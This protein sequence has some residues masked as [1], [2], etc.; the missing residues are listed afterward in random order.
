[1]DEI[2][3]QIALLEQELIA[4][5]RDFH[6]HPEL[7]FQ[8]FETA[9]KIENYLQEIGL[10]T[11]RVASTG[12]VATLFGDNAGKTIGLRADMDALPIDE[13]T[14]FEYSSVNQGVMHA[15]GHDAHMAMLLVAA[16]ILAK[17]KS[18]LGGKV[19]FIFQPNEETAGAQ[20]MIDA[21]VLQNPQVDACAAVHIW[22]LL[23]SGVVG[24]KSGAVMSN[25]DVFKIKIIGKDGHTGA[26]EHAIDPIIAAADVILTTQSIQT[27]VL[28]ALKPT[29]IMFT[30]VKG[31]SLKNNVIPENAY[32]EG[33]IR[34]L[35]QPKEN[36][37]DDP[38]ELFRKKVQQICQT[39]RCK[40]QIDIE[41]EN[42]VVVNDGAM[43][44]LSRQVLGKIV[45][46]ENL[47]DYSSMASEDFSAFADNVPSVFVHLG[48][49]NEKKGAK[50]AHHNSKFNVD[51]EVMKNGVKYFV[52][53]AKEFL[54][55]EK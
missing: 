22:S 3:K 35:F 21:G 4:L 29:V 54:K 49:K 39:H 47:E 8:E 48:C 53:M 2:D 1:M 55:N 52:E 44:D 26:P 12:V 38:A 50:F 14:N 15:C 37:S 41:R 10:Q 42:E 19:K 24:V 33:T 7:G 34:Y 23:P 16:K 36:K 27:R 13:E 17:S 51:E 20:K 6:K 11:Q 28:G 43:V 40:V 5:R 32:L 25:M 31:G 45:G 9:G 46:K 30:Q 18:E